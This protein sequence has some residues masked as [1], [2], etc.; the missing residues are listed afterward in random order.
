MNDIR[1]IFDSR[2]IKSELIPFIL[3]LMVIII[4]LIISFILVRIE[5]SNNKKIGKRKSNE[6]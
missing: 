2:I 3:I 5:L 6:K 4:V 1:W